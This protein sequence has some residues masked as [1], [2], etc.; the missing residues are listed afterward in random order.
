MFVLKFAKH[1]TEFKRLQ[2]NVIRITEKSNKIVRIF[3]IE[4]SK[5]ELILNTHYNVG[6]LTHG[7]KE[8]KP[9][10]YYY[11]DKDQENLLE[12]IRELKHLPLRARIL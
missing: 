7:L 1:K 3:P 9:K 4:F 12:S 11:F 8:F 2:E 10:F 6:K 5:T